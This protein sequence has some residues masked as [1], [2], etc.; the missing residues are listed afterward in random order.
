[1]AMV[2]LGI[3][4]GSRSVTAGQSEMHD[5]TAEKPGNVF[6]ESEPVLIRFKHEKNTKEWEWRVTDWLD[7]ECA[8]GNYGPADATFKIRG[9][10]LGYYRFYIREKGSQ[11][12][13]SKPLA[14]ARIFDFS[15]RKLNPDMPYAVGSCLTILGGSNPA[16]GPQNPFAP[17]NSFE[18]I[19]DLEKLAGLGFV[20]EYMSW[21]GLN[22]KPGE[23][24]WGRH[25]Q[26]ADFHSQRGIRTVAF[27]VSCPEWTSAAK[28]T[29]LPRDFL[30]LYRFCRE[31][32]AHFK[33]KIEA[34][35]LD[36]EIDGRPESAPAWEYAA[37]MKAACLGIKAGNPAANFLFVSGSATPPNLWTDMVMRNGVDGYFDVY[38]LHLYRA[39]S[40]YPDGITPIIQAEKDFLKKHGIAKPIWMTENGVKDEGDGKLQPYLPASDFREHDEEQERMQAESLVKSQITMQSLGIVKNFS[41][42]FPP[43]D[44]GGSKVWGLLRFD[45]T[46]KPGYVALA[47]LTQQ[48]GWS[49]FLGAI[50]LAPEVFGFLFADPGGSQTLVA[51]TKDSDRTVALKNQVEKLRMIDLMGKE[52]QLVSSNGTW[53]VAVGKYPVYLR[54]LRDLKP[55]QPAVVPDADSTASDTTTDKEVVLRI[56]FKENQEILGRTSVMLDNPA[57]CQASLDIF[58]FGKETKVVAVRNLGAG[59]ELEATPA[60]MSV[61]ALEC[62]AVP[63]AIQLSSPVNVVLKVGATVGGKQVS[64]ILVPINVPMVNNPAYR[65]QRLPTEDAARWR[66]NSAGKMQIQFDPAEQAVRFDTTFSKEVPAGTSRWIYPEF[67]LKLPEE[68]MAKTVGVSF[69]VKVKKFDAKYAGAGLMVDEIYFSYKPQSEQNKWQTVAISLQGAIPAGFDSGAIK[70]LRIGMN[71][72]ALDFTYWLKNVKV[73]YKK[74]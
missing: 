37:A 58:N 64:P 19:A 5:V 68:S 51:W 24:V 27:L 38:N 1:M 45:Y 65:T 70:L 36:N 10:P 49:R 56:R 7:R 9:L 67:P 25:G 46:V 18:V 62:R 59:Y 8:K 23:F 44:E 41:F 2:S 22:P 35:E 42:V 14:F 4:P 33:D 47:N 53:T 61:P 3:G 69:E 63:I 11:V 60:E 34:W 13:W 52:T 31:A 74:E 73:Y 43:F 21:G 28:Y 29:G 6:Q 26:N 40:Y 57:N 55:S 39:N 30:A 12:S 72:Q 32:A 48:L 15:S 16:Q 20:R 54:G 50:D 66:A 17:T 71:P